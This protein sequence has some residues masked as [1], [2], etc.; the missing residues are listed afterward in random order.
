MIASAKAWLDQQGRFAAAGWLLLG[1]CLILRLALPLADPPTNHLF[2]DPLRHWHNAERFFAPDLMS[3]MDPP[4]YQLFLMTLRVVFADSPLLLGLANGLLS[5]AVPLV[6]WV[7]ARAWGLSPPAALIAALLIGWHPSLIAHYNFFMMETLLVPLVGAATWAAGRYRAEGSIA[8]LL[9][10]VALWTLALLTKPNVAPL[11]I[12]LM[13]PGWWRQKQRYKLSHASLALALSTLLM[14]PGALRSWDY[15]GTFEPAGSPLV[16]R[17]VFNADAARI[18]V[19]WDGAGYHFMSPSNTI[20]PLRPFS[21][22]Q[23]KAARDQSEVFYR[24][25]RGSRGEDWKGVLAHNP[26][27]LAVRLRQIE[28]NAIQGIVADAWPDSTQGSLV[29][30]AQVHARWLWPPIVLVLAG[31]CIHALARRRTPA[32]LAAAGVLYLIFIAVQPLAQVEG[33]FR[34]PVEPILLLALVQQVQDRRQPGRT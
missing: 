31:G 26:R 20:A 34:K 10:A 28:E 30:M 15:F 33:R 25:S 8:W 16:S 27:P 29:G 21:A 11:G 14:L 9:G 6:Y 3:G 22:W 24:L 7:A 19:E 2:S 17:L 4:V 32:P 12:L 1:G 18:R 5:A 23:G 13:L